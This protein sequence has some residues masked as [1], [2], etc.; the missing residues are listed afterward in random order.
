MSDRKFW[1]DVKKAWIVTPPPQIK[2]VKTGS[3]GKID[4]S[5]LVDPWNFRTIVQSDN[6]NTDDEE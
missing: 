3:G 2:D 5:L 1:E 4:P 6:Q